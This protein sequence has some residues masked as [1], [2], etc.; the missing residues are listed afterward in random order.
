MWLFL[1]SQIFVHCLVHLYK[2]AKTIHK[3]PP[4]PSAAFTGETMRRAAS[5]GLMP[6]MPAYYGQGE[7]ETWLYLSTPAP[8]LTWYR[9]NLCWVK[10]ECRLL[11]PSNP[12]WSKGEMEL[13]LSPSLVPGI[14]RVSISTAVIL[15]FFPKLCARVN[16]CPLFPPISLQR[17]KTL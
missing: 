5:T 9:N 8:Q 12:T 16:A 10:S 17:K 13:S 6:P 14:A 1:S 15:L 7:L 11:P 2:G 4:I 3:K